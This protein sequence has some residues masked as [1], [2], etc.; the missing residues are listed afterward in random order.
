MENAE[1]NRKMREGRRVDEN[2]YNASLVHKH[3]SPLL[4]VPYIVYNHI[5]S[6]TAVK[7]AVYVLYHTRNRHLTS[8][9][10]NR[11]W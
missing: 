2:E 9:E 4:K 1:D 11:I 3:G 10:A 7:Q 6:F 5:L 8:P